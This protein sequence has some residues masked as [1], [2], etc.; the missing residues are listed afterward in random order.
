MGSPRRQSPTGVQV[1]SP[2]AR[3]SNRSRN[4]H[5]HH[6]HNKQQ[7]H[8][9]NASGQTIS[10]K[11]QHARE[12]NANLE[13][14]GTANGNKLPPYHVLDV[15]GSRG[16]FLMNGQV[17][18]ETLAS[19]GLVLPLPWMPAPKLGCAN[20]NAVFTPA[21][22]LSPVHIN[23]NVN[24]SHQSLQIHTAPPSMRVDSIQQFIAVD[25]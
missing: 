6:H 15:V 11:Q 4:K 12:S 9:P 5:H 23:V 24:A 14:N 8:E 22:A 13:P 21:M 18:V 16:L 20:S 17:P 10:S 25:Q 3:R 2:G 7:H 1:G 19:M